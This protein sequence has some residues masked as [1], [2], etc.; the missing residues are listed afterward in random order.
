MEMT[1][2]ILDELIGSLKDHNEFEILIELVIK[3]N[4]WEIFQ[5]FLNEFPSIIDEY[6]NPCALYFLYNFQN[7]VSLRNFQIL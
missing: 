2:P 1:A 7:R 4:R 3:V 6:L 5:I